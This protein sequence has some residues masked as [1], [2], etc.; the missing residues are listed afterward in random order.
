M[1]RQATLK[2]ETSLEGA[3]TELGI[4]YEEWKRNEKE[5][6]IGYDDGPYWQ[7]LLAH[8]GVPVVGISEV[9]DS[10]LACFSDDYPQAGYIVHRHTISKRMFSDKI[11]RAHV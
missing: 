6:S 9:A 2:E 8:A 5:R 3:S 11:G 7:F 4:A 1:S 10:E